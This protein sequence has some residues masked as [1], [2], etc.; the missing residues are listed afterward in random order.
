[1]PFQLENQIAVRYK[2]YVTAKHF[3][4]YDKIMSKEAFEQ[5][6]KRSQDPDYK[7]TITEAWTIGWNGK[8]I[9]N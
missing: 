8:C 9:S 6:Q 2:V 7:T 3:M 4:T 1:M 5:L